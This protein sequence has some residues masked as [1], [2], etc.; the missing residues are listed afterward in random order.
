MNAAGD[1]LTCRDERRR[2]DVRA[3][4][5]NGLDYLEV[6]DDAQRTLVVY[7]LGKAPRAIGTGNLRISGGRRVRD[8]AVT[9]VEVIRQADPALDDVMEVTVDRPGD[10]S[11]YVLQVVRA[12]ADGRPT[13]VPLD[14]FDTR[15]DRIA[16][17]FKAGCPSDLDCQPGRHCPDTPRAAPDINYLA[18]DYATLR[19][20]IL[21]RLALVMPDW[22]EAHAA[23][24]GIALVEL[25]AYTGDY[26]SYYQDA[27]ATEAY[28][29][30][31]RQRISVRRHARLVDYRMHE[32]CNARAWLTVETDVERS[33]DLAALRFV[34]AFPGAPSGRH[35]LAEHELPDAAGYETFA[36]LALD[37][38]TAVTFRPA[39]NRIALYTWGDTECCLARGATAATLRDGW[40]GD[41]DPGED[42]AAALDVPA[43]RERMLRLAPGDVLIFEE[44]VG[45]GTGAEGDA[46]PAHRQAV[47]LTAVT[48][49]IDALYGQPV[50]D[51]AWSPADAL[52]F[53]LCLSVQGPA[54]ACERL[55]DVSVA[56]GN[57]ILV[58]H[59]SAVAQDIGAV[60]LGRAAAHCPT[61]C[62]AAED[63]LVAAPFR[64]RLDAGPLTFAQPPAADS[65]AA[66]LL[67]Q[68]PRAALPGIVLDA[69]PA[70]PAGTGALF[71]F[72][73]LLDPAPL[74]QALRS[75]A[76]AG[77]DDPG[78][79]AARAALLAGL[80]PATR[81]ALAAWDPG[82]PPPAPLLQ[83]LAADLAALVAGWQPVPDLLDS[84]D[85]AGAFVA[86]IDNDGLAQLRFAARGGPA[87]GTLF[88]A[89]YRVGNGTAG[90]VGA[91]AI[92]YLVPRGIA[93]DGA[94]LVPRNPLAA[95]GGTNPEP[96]EQVRLLAPDAFRTRLARA[97]TADD[98]ATLAAMHPGVQ[99]AAATLRWTGSWQEVLVAIDPLGGVD[100]APALLDAIAADLE[101]YRRIG[102]DVVVR[103][104]RYVPLDV[105][106]RVCVAPGYLRGHV[107]VALLAALDSR[108]G[109]FQP[110]RLSFGDD[111]H[112]SALT[113]AAQAVAGVQDVTVVRLERTFEGPNDELRDGVLQLGPLEIA[114]LDNHPGMPEN[115]RL[116]LD[117]RGGR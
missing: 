39:H 110:D 86:E 97:V 37:E 17:T 54:P 72:A 104:A 70:A 25:L 15:Y 111:I 101:R 4:D 58:D 36:A 1:A 9:R 11:T 49:G 116:V 80:A 45:P 64:P 13:D 61:A 18:R 51:V 24:L 77:D 59:G 33:L 106:L 34:T 68:D 76:G 73:D 99:R 21:D 43:E 28:L 32:G 50:L 23:D 65:P 89:R 100:A 98:Y 38:R 107:K 103:P 93:L 31:A 5:L 115:G 109:F 52:A 56:R 30:T 2:A 19:Q 78:V 53:P 112:V 6:A 57:V 10:F 94:A 95:D 71:R 67:S 41:S 81:A 69:I 35:V 75:P 74:A 29:G 44:I 87:P 84:E 7:F 92:A 114:R 55:H 83:A 47:R 27:V 60:P 40:T 82:T 12:D 66:A 88:A 48:P 108:A 26:L 14:G 117:L 46:D 113:A 62:D 96:L 102:H 90:N 42:G 3:A 8:I 22:R 85:G 91:E 105:E 16:F 20:L 79:R 63:V